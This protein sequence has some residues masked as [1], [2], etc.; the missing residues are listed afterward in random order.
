[1][2]NLL[3]F[4]F[5]LGLSIGCIAQ[6]SLNM[7][8]MGHL[9]GL[10]LEYNDV[11]GY[12]HGTEEFAVIGSNTAV[13]IVNVTD[14]A[15]P[16]LVDQWVDGTSTIWRDIKD[17]EDY[18]YAI[19]DGGGC[20]EGL[21]VI[22][23]NDYSHTQS[24]SEFVRA[25]NLFVDKPSG[26]LYVMGSNTLSHGIYVY[27]VATDPSTPALIKSLNFRTLP[28]ESPSGNYYVHDA[29]F[30]NDTAYCNHGYPGMR[31]WDMRDLDNV[32]RIG[33]TG[34]NG[35]YNHSSWKHPNEDFLYLAEEVPIG[36]P[37]YI[38]DISDATD[39]FVE[40][41][42]KDPLEEPTHTN[43][44]PHNPLV[45]L[46]R[47]FISYYHDGVQVYDV[48]DPIDPERIAYYD[49]YPS[50]SSYSGY[51]GAWGTYPF[52][53]SGCILG[54]DIE[55]GLFTL[56]MTIAPE[57]RNK[58]SDSDLIVD[59][60]D[61]G[62]VFF[63]PDDGYYRITIDILGNIETETLGSQPNPVFEVINSN[64]QFETDDYGVVLRNPDGKYYRIGVN[65][66]GS[67]TST[68]V[69]GDPSS[70]LSL[71][72]EDIYFSQYRAGV[73]LKNSNGECYHFTLGESG[74]TELNL[75]GCD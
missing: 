19:C 42:F 10:G 72:S 8:Q 55:S 50:N 62:I 70:S 1:M 38:Y 15:N 7:K 25:H 31:I 2:K 30:E 48:S 23:K 61:K 40:L 66:S 52:L 57:A 5:S 67:L 20:T 6:D 64:V 24:T 34:N 18:L 44:R 14:C 12:R 9:S 49:T 27:D 60:P 4:I 68:L 3:I 32:Y 65:N 17:Y 26:R 35:G 43:N 46:N 16:V 58:I 36:R 41:T 39:P 45:H 63:T 13:N 51:N 33:D 29:Y 28:G 69:A 71:T 47:L 74:A 75:I 59:D 56:R 22:N 37:M 54:S 53:P 11:W 73:I 21:Q